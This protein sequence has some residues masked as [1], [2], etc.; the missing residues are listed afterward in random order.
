MVFKVEHA[1]PYKVKKHFDEVKVDPYGLRVQPEYQ[2]TDA[3]R[4]ICGVQH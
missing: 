2:T 1:A 3:F 4:D